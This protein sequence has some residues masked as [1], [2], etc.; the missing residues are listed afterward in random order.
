MRAMEAAAKL[1]AVV[2][3]FNAAAD[4]P[5]ALAS[6]AG[7]EVIIADGGSVD[8]TVSLGRA[9]GAE[10]IETQRG[11]GAQMAAGADAGLTRGAAWLLFLHADTVLP[12]GWQDEVGSFIAQKGNGDK[13]AI[14]R[15]GLDD[16]SAAA[17]R[18]EAI[19][20]WRNRILALPYGDQ[21]LLISRQLYERIGG[22][23]PLPIMEDV[24]I[25]RRLGKTRLHFLAGRAV[26]SAAKFRRRGYLMRSTRNLFCL[27]LFFLRVPP[28]LIA[29]IYG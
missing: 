27:A 14:F 11:R 7:V 20:A 8:E 16:D 10:V 28:P 3:T 6:L 25:I 12:D 4:L 19:V 18:L 5:A 24:D 9:E 2:P 1:I 17:R 22:F 23:R 29:R 26:T 21:G 15:F 13:A